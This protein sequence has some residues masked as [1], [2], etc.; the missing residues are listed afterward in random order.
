M[1]RI[2]FTEIRGKFRG[3]DN[4]VTLRFSMTLTEDQARWLVETCDQVGESLSTYARKATL[5]RLKRDGQ[6]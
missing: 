4:K 2:T 3:T 1:K 5:E 6:G